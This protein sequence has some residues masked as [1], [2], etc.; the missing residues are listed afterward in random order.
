M[1]PFSLRHKKGLAKDRVKVSLDRRVRSRL[2]STAA[3]FDESYYYHPNPNDNWTEITTLLDD[4]QS[5]FMRVVG[6]DELAV[7]IDDALAKADLETFFK[8]GNPV[9]VLDILEVFFSRVRDFGT[10]G[11]ERAW[12]LQTEINGAMSDFEQPWRLSDGEFFKIDSEFLEREIIQNAEDKLRQQG[13]AGALDEFREA[14]DDHT[15]GEYRD[16][17]SKSANSVESTLKVVTGSTGDLSKLPNRFSSAISSTTFR[18]TSKRPLG[19]CSSKRWAFF[20][21]NSAATGKSKIRST[22][23]SRRVAWR[24]AYPVY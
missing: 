8:T 2:W 21:M 6:V 13:F 10:E 9:H 12:D 16:T 4:T 23:R 17:I 24:S 22:L 11:R 5:E 7:V 15:D 19:R 18:Q 1:S 20:A 3:K 14:R